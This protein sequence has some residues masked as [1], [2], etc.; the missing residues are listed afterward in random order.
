MKKVTGGGLPARI[1]KAVMSDAESSLP[2]QALATDGTYY[3]NNTDHEVD[4]LSEAGLRDGPAPSSGG[5][6]FNDLIGD[7]I[8]N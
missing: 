3:A 1:W 7:L 5:G 4:P 8:G 2:A 6:G